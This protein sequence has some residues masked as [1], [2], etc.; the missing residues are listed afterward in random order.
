M[1]NMWIMDTKL[2][3]DWLNKFQKNKKN[4]LLFV[5]RMLKGKISSNCCPTFQDVLSN[6]NAFTG[7]KGADQRRTETAVTVQTQEER[8]ARP[9]NRF[10]S[11][12]R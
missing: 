11:K 5:Q 10:F 4:K 3:Y 2:F 1:E 6:K 9:T 8:A 7:R 12:S